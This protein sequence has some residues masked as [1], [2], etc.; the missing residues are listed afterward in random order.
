MIGLSMGV[1]GQFTRILGPVFGNA[2]DYAC[3]NA[4]EATAPGQITVEDILNVY[5][6]RSLNSETA[7]YG[8]IGDPVDESKGHIVHN[9]AMKKLGLN[10]VYVKMPVKPQELPDYFRKI[11]GLNFRGLSVTMPLKEPVMA[12]LSRIDPEAEKIGAVNTLV[13]E[14]DGFAGYNTDGVGALDAIEKRIPVKGKKMVFL[15]AGG[16]AKGVA[17]EARSRGAK[18]VILNRTESKAEALAKELGGEW[19]GLSDVP[20]QYD[21]LVNSTSEDMPISADSILPE[22]V[23]FDVVYRAKHTEF[24]KAAENKRCVLVF[25]YEMFVNQAAAQ[26]ELWFRRPKQDFTSSLDVIW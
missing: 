12:H 7:I 21:V 24:L 4:K 11:K 19:G 6:Y 26:F 25:G 20:A 15:G 14:E 16:S 8:L 13:F 23:V 17:Y 9:Q 5:N 18:I 1:P 22:K 10:A 2:I 3:L